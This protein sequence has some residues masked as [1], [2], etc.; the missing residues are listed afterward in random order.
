MS[1]SIT[2]GLIP[3]IKLVNLSTRGRICSQIALA[4]WPQTYCNIS[5]QR[6]DFW[7][8]GEYESCRIQPWMRESAKR[9]LYT[10]RWGTVPMEQLRHD[11]WNEWVARWNGW[12]T[13]SNNCVWTLN[14]VV[15]HDAE[16]QSRTLVR[17]MRVLHNTHCHSEHQNELIFLLSYRT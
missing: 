9:I 5:P 6:F 11:R 10:L 4:Y 3:T 14:P 15:T 12:E 16:T 2:E 7:A 8:G 13:H 17:Y 1:R